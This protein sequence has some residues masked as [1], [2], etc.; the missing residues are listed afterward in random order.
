MWIRTAKNGKTTRRRTKHH[1]IVRGEDRPADSPSPRSCDADATSRNTTCYASGTVVTSPAHPHQARPRR[2]RRPRR[3]YIRLLPDG[4]A[5]SHGDVRDRPS[6]Q[7]SSDSRDGA[8]FTLH[9]MMCAH[10]VCAAGESGA[11]TRTHDAAPLCQW[12]D[13]HRH[14]Q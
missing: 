7:A 6:E 3:R 12:R 1:T 9:A 13:A 5:G 8:T 14:A 2:P 4:A 11:S 10:V